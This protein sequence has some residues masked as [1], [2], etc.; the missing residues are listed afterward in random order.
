MKEEKHGMKESRTTYEQT[1]VMFNLNMCLCKKNTICSI[2][3]LYVHILSIMSRLS[4]HSCCF[5]TTNLGKPV[6]LS[7]SQELGER[8]TDEAPGS[9]GAGHLAPGTSRQRPRGPGAAGDVR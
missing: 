5:S 2:E 6:R 8:M 9:A 3:S 4:L 1:P 7:G